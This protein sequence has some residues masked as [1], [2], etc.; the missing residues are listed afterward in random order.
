[1]KDLQQKDVDSSYRIQN[2]VTPCMTQVITNSAHGLRGQC[3]G[4]IRLELRK[5]LRDSEGHP[6]ATVGMS[7]LAPQGQ[8]Q[9]RRCAS[10]HFQ[11]EAIAPTTTAALHHDAV[12]AGMLFQERQ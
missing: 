12:A 7:W 9:L 10:K 8:L 11:Q 3:L 4:H 2:T 1:M 5:D 6:W